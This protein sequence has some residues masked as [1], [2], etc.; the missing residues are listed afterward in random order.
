[1]WRPLFPLDRVLVSLDAESWFPLAYEVVA[2]SSPDRDEWALGNDLPIERPGALLLRVTAT[3]FDPAVARI[4]VLPPA[5]GATDEGFRELDIARLPERAGE[6]LV[7]RD[8][9]RL[10]PYR[11]GIF[12]G[13][14]RPRD[15]ILL[16]FSRGLAWL[17]IRQTR[18]WTGPDLFGDVT[19]LAA[20]VPLANGGVAYYEPATATLGRRLSIHS[21]DADLYLESNLPRG[22]LFRVAA[23]IPVLGRP[24][25]GRWLVRRGPEGIVRLQVPVD[26]A[27][28]AVPGLTLPAP[29]ALPAGYELWTANLVERVE[30]TSVAVYY[31]RPGA[32]LDG[33]GIGLWQGPGGELAP[34]LDPDVLRVRL[35]DV[36]GRYS[37]SRGELEWTED[38]TYRRLSAPTLPLTTLLRVAL[39]LEAG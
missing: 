15:E 26:E 11:S 4:P 37:P 17:K 2:A 5:P 38:G 23:S 25:P 10:L 21:P 27:R 30:G 20:P 32:E 9:R 34:P 12:A 35:D 3:S 33:Q 16:S 14:G 13:G 8:L 22:E 29:S 6:V 7:P 19:T 31:R 39:S 28:A 18:T 24:V 1:V 36:I